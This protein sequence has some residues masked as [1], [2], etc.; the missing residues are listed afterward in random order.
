MNGVMIVPTAQAHKITPLKIAVYIKET[1]ERITAVTV[2]LFRIQI[3]IFIVC[4]YN[5]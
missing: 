5:I 2:Y 1:T 3:E 4:S